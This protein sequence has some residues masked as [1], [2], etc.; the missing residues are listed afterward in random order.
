MADF[1]LQF[2]AAAVE[3]IL[4][5]IAKK[6]GGV[7]RLGVK[8]TG[9]S[10]YMYQPDIIE[11]PSDNDI[12]GYQTAKFEAYVDPAALPIIQGTQIDFVEK[13]FGMK[14]LVYDNP[15]A[16]GLCGCGES[17]HLNEEQT[18]E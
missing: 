11:A 16:N 12:I 14:Q 5:I 7:F 2:S 6:G 10:G 9:C 8:Q 13:S 3:H 18:D 17:F 1:P 15:N 4:G